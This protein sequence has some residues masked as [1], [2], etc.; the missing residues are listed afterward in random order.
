M[1]LKLLHLARGATALA[2]WSVVG[3][4]FCAGVA[5]GQQIFSNTSTVSNGAAPIEQSITTPLPGPVTVTL[6]D[7]GLVAAAAGVAFPVP[8]TSLNLA[9]TIG[10]TK[11][12][13]LVGPGKTTFQAAANG[14]YVVRIVGVPNASALGQSGSVNVLLEQG[15]TTLRQFSGTI[16]TPPAANANPSPYSVSTQSFKVTSPGDYSLTLSD[17]SFPVGLTVLSA[18]VLLGTTPVLPA[19]IQGPGTTPLPGLA[20]GTYQVFIFAQAAG[21][22]P[23]GVYGLLVAP[24]AGAALLDISV[25][26]ATQGSPGAFV[27]G[28][29]TVQDLTARD[30]AEPAALSSLTAMVTNGSGKLTS[31]TGGGAPGQFTVP[32]QIAT[33]GLQVWTAAQAA[34]SNAGAYTVTVSP[35]GGGNSVFSTQAAVSASPSLFPYIAT[36]PTGGG[37]YNVVV[38]DLQFPAGLATLTYVLYQGGMQLYQGTGGIASPSQTLKAGPVVLAVTATASAAGSGLF[39]A[40][41]NPQGGGDALL[42]TTQAVTASFLTQDIVVTNSASYDVTL[43]D[44]GWPDKFGTLELALTQGGKNVAG[45]IYGGGTFTVDNVAPG[46]YVATIVAVPAAGQT[47]GLYDLSV[48]ESL[49]TATL[50]ATPTIIPSGQG[51]RLTWS[52]TNA[53]SCDATGNGWT[54]QKAPSGSGVAVGPLTATTT[55]TLTCSGSSG[56]SKPASVTITVTP[57]SGGGGGGGGTLGGLELVALGISALARASRTVRTLRRMPR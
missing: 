21:S 24:T 1:H 49:P 42:D 56:K 20:A 29:G 23:A 36:M 34:P 25:P 17:Q 16:Q 57:A 11:V 30:L 27:A 18:Q 47:A 35:S 31:M 4:A 51:T 6:T 38:T 45:K 53:T 9:V 22:P 43:A 32:A 55:Y 13:T 19:T 15:G 10:G 37:S 46:R 52:S 33:S 50:S 7:L 8:L 28:S 39:A 54:G 26:V 5:R 3:V 48:Q 44:L 14:T 2:A 12:A 40:A 41:L